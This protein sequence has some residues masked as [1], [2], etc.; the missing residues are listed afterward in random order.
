MVET[1][2][3]SDWPLEAVAGQPAADVRRLTVEPPPLAPT[4]GQRDPGWALSIFGFGLIVLAGLAHFAEVPLVISGAVAVLGIGALAAR[5][6][7]ARD[8][9]QRRKLQIR[10]NNTIRQE[11][12]TLADRLW[13]V[14][15]SEERFRG[16]IDAVGDIVVHRDVA[17]RI[18]YANSV[19]GR[20]TG[21]AA[22]S[23]YG[24]T[25]FDIGIDVPVPVVEGDA[26]APQLSFADVAIRTAEGQRWYAWTELSGRD[27]STGVII[28]RAIARDITGRKKAEAALLKARERAELASNAKSRF[29]AT[30]SHEIRTPMN[31][32]IGM[33]KLLAHTPLSPEQSTYVSAV[34]T[35]A[36]ALLALM[37][38]VLDF[39]KIEAGRIDIDLQPTS[40][41]E[42]A[43]NVVELLS[44]RAFA[45]GLGIASTI[46]PDV[47]AIV[48]ADP[49][50]LRQ[51]LMNLVGNALKFTEQGGV[52]VAVET[53]ETDGHTTLKLSVSDTGPG[54]SDADA[55]RVFGEFEQAQLPANRHEG[56]GLGLAISRRIMEAMGGTLS[57]QSEPRK[58]ATFTAS[59][60]VSG[61]AGPAPQRLAGWQ[62]LILSR[63]PMEAEAL[64]RTITAEGGQVRV[65]EE[66]LSAHLVW[67]LQGSPNVALVD[68]GL[69]VVEGEQL[70]MLASV[71]LRPDRA[72]TMIAPSDR[73]RL[74]RYRAAGFSAFLARPIRSG[75]L[76]RFLIADE[77]A[78]APRGASLPSQPV[79]RSSNALSVLV[80]DDN[81]VNSMLARAALERSG[82]SVRVVTNGREA[83]ESLEGAGRAHFDVLLLDMHMPVMDGLET[84]GRLRRIEDEQSLAPIPIIILSA[85]GQESA[86]QAAFAHGADGFL[87]KPVD[88]DRLVEA[89][90][91]KA[92]GL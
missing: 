2:N 19:L 72:V 45:K 62:V 34:S 54:L 73:S 38:D 15:E 6:L 25:L 47:P 11:F 80:A 10:R 13:E 75:T 83:I 92:S 42:L 7:A 64:R 87:L 46:A 18:T 78:G 81:P 27:S 30:V 35:S 5:I 71:G 82:H 79:G 12:D 44:V 29:L 68:A 70:Q 91:A 77:A 90:E 88:P 65:A 48:E 66:A 17:G 36:H 20:L 28:H 1:R 16:L 55:A 61:K 52:L 76:V 31:G 89:V 8:E 14:Q 59:L 50:R 49:D 40:V 43:E 24:R 21:E 86:R 26:E 53:A 4:L 33:A 9:R 67:D 51:V 85:D 58:G 60:P 74:S 39:S 23:F 56:A 84:V 32:I 41:R 63:S 22:R 57:V 3:K 69:E 37:E